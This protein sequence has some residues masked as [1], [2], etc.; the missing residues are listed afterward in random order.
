LKRLILMRHA[1]SDWAPPAQPDHD[2]PL[3]T[4]GRHAATAMGD[5]LRRNGLTPGQILCSSAARTQETCARLNLPRTPDLHATLYLA[6][7]ADMLRVL[8]GAHGDTV[9]MIGHNPG[10]AA[11]AAHLVSAPPD[12]PRFDDYPTGAT[13]VAEFDIDD[14]AELTRGTGRVRHFVI[15][16]DLTDNR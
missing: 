12:H 14:W 4:R 7:A 10:I 3:N 13:L 15:P 9:L 8:H 11:L 6:E 16:R 2:R 1:K 5:W